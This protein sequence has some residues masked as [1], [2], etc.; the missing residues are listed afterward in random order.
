LE[1]QCPREQDFPSPDFFFFDLESQSPEK[2]KSR[3]VKVNLEKNY[4]CFNGINEI[5]NIIIETAQRLHQFGERIA[6]GKIVQS[7]KSK[8]ASGLLPVL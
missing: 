6:V 7:A 1:S 5:Q 2:S 8:D 4:L 3:K